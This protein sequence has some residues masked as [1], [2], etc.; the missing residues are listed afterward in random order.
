MAHLTSSV[1]VIFH[2]FCSGSWYHLNMQDLPLKP[3]DGLIHVELLFYILHF[4]ILQGI[5]DGV[6]PPIPQLLV[7]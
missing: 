5:C 7:H 3:I 6:A 4:G 1:N 2:L